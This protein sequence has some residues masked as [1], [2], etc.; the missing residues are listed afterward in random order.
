M[1][2]MS[3]YA[4]RKRPSTRTRITTRTTRK[5]DTHADGDELSAEERE[6]IT[7]GLEGFCSAAESSFNDL[8]ATHVRTAKFLEAVK[9]CLRAHSVVDQVSS[10]GVPTFKEQK[11]FLKADETA[12]K[13]LERF[14]ALYVE[15]RRT[16]A[17][18]EADC[19][20]LQDEVD[21]E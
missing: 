17:D 14:L 9:E 16:K 13:Q 7:S 19:Q 1:L 21:E 11:T 20:K 4:T 3:A 10:M 18:F 5:T 8:M 6:E 12:S 2:N 15:A